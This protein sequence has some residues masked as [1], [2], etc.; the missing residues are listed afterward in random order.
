MRRIARTDA[1]T[2]VVGGVVAHTRVVAEASPDAPI[3]GSVGHEEDYMRTSSKAVGAVV[4]S[5]VSGV[6]AGALVGLPAA[7]SAPAASSDGAPDHLWSLTA[8]N[9][10]LTGKDE[11]D[12]RLKLVGVSRAVGRYA[13]RPSRDPSHVTIGQFLREW[14]TRFAFAPPNAVVTY[15]V[16]RSAAPRQVQVVLSRPRYDKSSDTMR[17]AAERIHRT[18]DDLPDR[19]GQSTSRPQSTVA[20]TGPVSVMIDDSGEAPDPVPPEGD[21]PPV[22]P[23]QKNPPAGSIMPNFR[24]GGSVAAA[25]SEFAVTIDSVPAKVVSGEPFVVEGHTSGFSPGNWINVWI[26]GANGAELDAGGVIDSDDNRFTVTT[27][28]IGQGPVQLQVSAGV[29]PEEQ[30][31]E[32]VSLNVTE[33]S[34]LGSAAAA[35]RDVRGGTV[36]QAI[37]TDIPDRSGLTVVEAFLF[38]I[39][40]PSAKVVQPSLRS[41][42][43]DTWLYETR[44]ATSAADGPLNQVTPGSEVQFSTQKTCY[45]W[46]YRGLVRQPWVEVSCPAPRPVP[47]VMGMTGAEAAAAIEKAGFTVNTWRASWDGSCY[48][49]NFWADAPKIWGTDKRVIDQIPRPAER[50]TEAKD[51]YIRCDSRWT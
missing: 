29:W 32:S 12:M 1:F 18:V 49:I 2:L 51:I 35:Y 42:P 4:L 16:E 9:G 45:K 13:D 46:M 6:A 40:Q 47:D 15:Q 34:L 14:E 3:L 33:P 26:K 11:A 22:A 39:G 30:W 7:E 23:T 38:P 24:R 21:S 27:R 43:Q 36:I 10:S 44:F 8:R 25:A 50:I 48:K 28:L 41:G 37:A 17:F 20:R 31:S 5:V 19:T